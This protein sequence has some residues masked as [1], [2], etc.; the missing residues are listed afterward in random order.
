METRAE[1]GLVGLVFQGLGVRVVVVVVVGG[2]YPDP[3]TQT[4]EFVLGVD[5]CMGVWVCIWH[6]RCEV[7]GGGVGWLAPPETPPAA[8]F[9]AIADVSVTSIPTCLVSFET[10]M[11]AGELFVRRDQLGSVDLQDGE[12]LCLVYSFPT[13]RLNPPPL[14]LAR[15]HVALRRTYPSSLAALPLDNLPA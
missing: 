12:I 8:Q 11:R 2:I 1:R 6:L 5:G 3:G 9:R 13:T 4:R 10:V 15:P 14:P 7:G